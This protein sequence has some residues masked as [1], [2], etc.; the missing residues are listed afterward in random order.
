MYFSGALLGSGSQIASET[1][2]PMPKPDH[3]ITPNLDVDNGMAQ[4]AC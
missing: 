1:Q 2:L 3:A 4:D